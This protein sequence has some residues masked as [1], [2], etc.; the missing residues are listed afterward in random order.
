[1]DT[2]RV[3]LWHRGESCSG[4]AHAPVADVDQ[5]FRALAFVVLSLGAAAGAV[6]PVRLPSCIDSRAVLGT[7]TIVAFCLRPS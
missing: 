5:E 6:I 2:R 4:T 1:M 3:V 7:S